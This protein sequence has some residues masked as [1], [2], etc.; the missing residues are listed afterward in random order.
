MSV[1]RA[2]KFVPM[3]VMA[4]TV[5]GPVC[6][7]KAAAGVKP[8]QIAA[9]EKHVFCPTV[10]LAA[11]MRAVVALAK[12]FMPVMKTPTVGLIPLVT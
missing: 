2:L 4:K 12:T 8:P 11:Q 9:R 7:L 6:W 10:S 3:F 1:P 5:H